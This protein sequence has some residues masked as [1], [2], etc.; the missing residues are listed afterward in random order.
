MR[1]VRQ[2]GYAHAMELLLSARRFSSAELVT[3]GVINQAVA[4]ADVEAAAHDTAARIAALSPTAV[5]TIKEAVLT[6]QDLPWT[7]AFAQEAVLG[8]RT[9][10][11]EDARKG[12]A[13]FAA[14]AN[15]RAEGNK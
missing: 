11:S 14:R 7:E 12:L 13:A 3:R 9:F 10:A 15:S 5:Q 8:Q 6:L 1:L 4:A 2:I